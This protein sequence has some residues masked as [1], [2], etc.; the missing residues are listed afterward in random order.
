MIWYS[1][2]NNQLYHYTWLDTTI[3][4]LWHLIQQPISLY[5]LIPQS[6]C[7]NTWYSHLAYYYT[8]M[9]SASFPIILWYSRYKINTLL[10]YSRYSN[11]NDM[12]LLIQQSTI[13]LHMTWYNNLYVMTLDT[14]TINLYTTWYHNLYVMILDTAIST[15]T[16]QQWFSKLSYALMILLIQNK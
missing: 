13:L 1:W 4:M 9:D 8:T 16:K 14:T 3:F 2:Y 6:L 15:I 11:L 10:S 12:I 5:N 7:Y